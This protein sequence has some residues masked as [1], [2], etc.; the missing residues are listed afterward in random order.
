M[1]KKLQRLLCMLLAAAIVIGMMPVQAFA[2][3]RC[4]HAPKNCRWVPS[5]DRDK[6]Q[7]VCDVCGKILKI[8]NHDPDEQGENTEYSC[9]VSGH[10]KKCN[11]CGLIWDLEQHSYN[12]VDQTIN[13][14]KH[15]NIPTCVY[16]GYYCTQVPELLHKF[17]WQQKNGGHVYAC[18]YCGCGK[19]GALNPPASKHFYGW[20]YDNYSHYEMCS[21]CGDIKIKSAH[22][23]KKVDEWDEELP[24]KVTK[25]HAR[26]SCSNENCGFWYIDK[27]PEVY[28]CD[29][30]HC[31]YENIG[32]QHQYV[33]DDCRYV[34]NT[35]S[36]SIDASKTWSAED[37]E[38]YFAQN[39]SNGTGINPHDYMQ[40]YYSSGH[41]SK[42]SV[43]SGGVWEPHTWKK[44]SGTDDMCI[45]YC[46]KC[47]YNKTNAL[48]VTNEDP[49]PHTYFEFS[50][51]FVNSED[52]NTPPRQDPGVECSYQAKGSGVH[53]AECEICGH[54]HREKCDSD[55]WAESDTPG[56]HWQF[57]SK[58]GGNMHLTECTEGYRP[59]TTLGRGRHEVYC[60]VCNK[61]VSPSRNCEYQVYDDGTENYTN[62]TKHTFRCTLCGEQWTGNHIRKT[63]KED[64]HPATQ[65]R[66]GYYWEVT[67]CKLCGMELTRQKINLPAVSSGDTPD[68]IIVR[69]KSVITNVSDMTDADTALATGAYSSNLSQYVA[70]HAA[71]FLGDNFTMPTEFYDKDNLHVTSGVYVVIEPV[72]NVTIT[73]Y[74]QD[75]DDY[76]ND[77]DI[78]EF[79][80]MTADISLTYNAYAAADV[81]GT[82][83]ISNGYIKNNVPFDAND[84]DINLC[85]PVLD[86]E[87]SQTVLVYHEHN[88]TTN[89]YA[90]S[91]ASDNDMATV[92]FTTSHG[93]SAFTFVPTE[94]VLEYIPRIEPT[95]DTEGRKAYWYSKNQNKYYYDVECKNEITDISDTVIPKIDDSICVI[96]FDADGGN[97]YM[98]PVY[99]PKGT[100]YTLPKGT[101]TKTGAWADGREYIMGFKCWHIGSSQLNSFEGDTYTVNYNTILHCDYQVDKVYSIINFD[102]NGGEGTMEPQRAWNGETVKLSPN[103]YTRAGYIFDGWGKTATASTGYYVDGGSF[104]VPQSATTLYAVWKPAY[105][106]HFD[107]NGGTGE[108]EDQIVSFST[109]S[110]SAYVTFNQNTYEREGYTLKGW[111]GFI[112]GVEKTVT[113]TYPKT[114]V[115]KTDFDENNTLTVT[116]VWNPDPNYRPDVSSLISMDNKTVAYN[117]QPQTIEPTIDF[118]GQ[119]KYTQG[120]SPTWTYAYYSGY[121][122][123]DEAKL[124]GAPVNAGTYTVVATYNDGVNTGKK[125]RYLWINKA[126]RTL[127]ISTEQLDLYKTNGTVTLTVSEDAD[128]SAANALTL[129]NQIDKNVVTLGD[130]IWSGNTATVP[131]NYVGPGFTHQLFTLAASD[132]YIGTNAGVVISAYSGYRVNLN[133]SKGGRL[134]TDKAKA[135]PGDEVT[136]TT[137]PYTGY[138]LDSLTVTNKAANENIAVT[139]GKF[140][141]P[142]ADVEVN[143]AYSQE[144]YT[145][146]YADVD[147]VTY[148][149]QPMTAH[150][151]DNITVSASSDSADKVIKGFEYTSGGS[152]SSS[153]QLNAAEEYSFRMP[154]KNVTVK[155]VTG[156]PYDVYTDE[157]IT[158]GSVQATP[159]K[160]AQGMTVKIMPTAN[161][162]YTLSNVS[163]VYAGS[164]TE[165]PVKVSVDALG[166]K[167]YTITMPANDVTVSAEFISNADLATDK[168][169]D[170]VSAEKGASTADIEVAADDD[171]LEMLKNSALSVDVDF[172]LG[173]SGIVITDE[174][175]ADALSALTAAGF[176]DGSDNVRIVEKN[177]MNVAVTGYEN[178]G[179][180]ISMTFNITPMVQ[181]A[182]TTADENEILDDK[183]S[184][185]LAAPE[186][187]KIEGATTLSFLIPSELAI[188]AGGSGNTVYI[189]HTHEGV[190]YEYP[191]TVMYDTSSREYYITFLNPNG[192][193]EFTLSVQ[194]N[195]V[196]SYIKNDVI[197]YYPSFNEA[198]ADA[199]ENNVTAITMHKMP[200]TDDKALITKGMMLYFKAADGCE[201]SIDFNALYNT[202][203]ETADGVS[204]ASDE[205][206]LTNH[207]FVYEC[208]NGADTAVNGIA[209]DKHIITLASGDTETLTATVKPEDAANKN[210]TWSSDN[211]SVAEVNNGVVTAVGTGV[212]YISVTTEDGGRTDS[213]KV[214][215]L[216]NAISANVTGYAGMYDGE[217]HGITVNAPAGAVVKYGLTAG[218]YDLDESPTFTE[219]G[220]YTVYYKITADGC[221]TTTGAAKVVISTKG[222]VNFDG[223]I[224][225]ADAALVLKY[226][227][228][229][230]PFYTDETKNAKAKLAADVDNKEG[231]DMLDVIAIL[232]MAKTTE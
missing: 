13:G 98:E 91:Y 108:M 95:V 150:Y 155:A 65:N 107:P 4:A 149:T 137:K 26:Y 173:E 202:F 18:E 163:C 80:S 37:A 192:Y 110:T 178:S 165:V 38:R 112:N 144:E 174:D 139:N 170:E 35:S 69:Q 134:L 14:V 216:G 51:V 194:S 154:A 204:K 190:N 228:T 103:K 187:S 219:I 162:G 179:G 153:I 129:Y 191:A 93:C 64:Y 135:M 11:K 100:E 117:G 177:F 208:Y 188:E 167:T 186:E 42:C 113:V 185:A 116:A 147:G 124:T 47:G 61:I 58:C 75:E 115:Y 59:S 159:N 89:V 82:E 31:H 34:R 199:V 164:N 212:A 189:Q 43:C 30:P 136:I 125:D 68:N 24:G 85:V 205:S 109:V 10:I 20:C 29:H 62:G 182:A 5:K 21:I 121:E 217:A 54:E 168:V 223:K 49:D 231:I 152:T 36:H 60:K 32:G 19:N 7:Y 141:M 209:L 77:D 28:S 142:A 145:V 2:V 158:N 27:R 106:I 183:N 39:N 128:N 200:S 66:D 197:Y 211:T 96:T 143:V 83:H 206:D 67:V 9:T 181:K 102:A 161:D 92:D 222:D 99:V 148:T 41:M 45:V 101:F 166:E 171:T 169:S 8:E 176:T 73:D 232:D 120:S 172:E 105:Y 114:F 132:N 33:C 44:G 16:C 15:P 213:C 198:I 133:Y 160:A 157:N 156:S 201:E 6:H 207:L 25:H 97:G 52:P 87:S 126:P 70:E 86:I 48:K 72:I 230:K 81:N 50:P 22:N 104:T 55:G 140:T 12:Y 1:N 214:V 221:D 203:I 130:I 175:K 131:V 23:M 88:G 151:G 71:D 226:I 224:T 74:T 46:E 184:V 3:M 227:S 40:G 123:N 218:T 122:V 215:V 90:G 53:T 79:R 17:G 225:D 84:A 138:K 195:T 180:N 210:V 56:K 193:S 196:A 94:H 220:T 127:T 119:D 111:K 146:S 229:N 78:Y 76:D 63:I 57:C 118:S